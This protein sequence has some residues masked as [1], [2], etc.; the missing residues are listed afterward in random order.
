M[1]HKMVNIVH[2]HHQLETSCT[3]KK[4]LSP[5]N[6]KKWID[7]NETEFTTYSFG[8]KD[9]AGEVIIKIYQDNKTY[10]SKVWRL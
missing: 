1:N 8:H 4:S 9:I 7:K 6:D 2:D 3:L 10:I 5:F